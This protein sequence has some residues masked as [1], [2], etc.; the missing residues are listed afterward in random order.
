[1][2]F[3]DKTGILVQKNG[4]PGIEFEGGDSMNWTGHFYSL[5]D[6]KSNGMVGAIDQ[7]DCLELYIENFESKEHPGLYVRHPNVAQSRYGWASY[8]D[9]NWRGVESRDQMTGKLCFFTEAEAKGALW[10]CFKQHLK[11]GLVFANNTIHNGDDPNDYKYANTWKLT[12]VRKF[13]DLTLFDIWA[14]YIRGFRAWYLYLFL[15]LFDFHLLGSVISKKL[16]GDTDVISLFLKQLTSRKIMST[17]I[18]WLACQ[19]ISGEEMKRRLKVY[20]CGWRKQPGM[21]KLC[22]PMVDRYWR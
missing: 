19:V 18:G 13:P 12:K 7:W 16:N 6:F 14:L 8:C 21:Y 20:W 11:R 1:M 5:T 4:S 22:V 17:P 9:G 3:R 15:I 10:R 2:I